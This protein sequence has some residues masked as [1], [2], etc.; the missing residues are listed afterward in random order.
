MRFLWSHCNTNH[1]FCSSMLS[2]ECRET[3]CEDSAHGCGWVWVNSCNGQCVMIYFY[4]S[5]SFHD[6]KNTFQNSL[7]SFNLRIV[8]SIA[9]QFLLDGSFLFLCH[10]M[11]TVCPFLRL[12]MDLCG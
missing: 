12:R 1:D 5:N 2:E 4:S 10:G 7:F 3:N 9:S 6:N 11:G 8:G